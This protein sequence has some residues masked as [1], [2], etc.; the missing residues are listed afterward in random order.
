M[1]Q[2]LEVY[3]HRNET[4]Y[5][6]A[7]KKGVPQ[8]DSKR[9]WHNWIRQVLSFVLKQM[10]KSSQRQLYTTMK[11]YS[12]RIR[13]LAFLNKG[14]QITLRDERDEEN[15]RRRLLSL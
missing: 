3:V 1:S 4:I 6:Q 2:D 10:E 8:F 9:S 15:V 5:H 7:Y 12:K 11:H 14:I 13:E